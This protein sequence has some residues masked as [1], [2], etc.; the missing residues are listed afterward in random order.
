MNRVEKD[1]ERLIVEGEDDR[2]LVKCPYLF[3]MEWTVLKRTQIASL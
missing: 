1:G 3:M 2:G